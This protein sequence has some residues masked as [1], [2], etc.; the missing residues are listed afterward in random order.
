MSCLLQPETS[1]H[2]GSNTESV[3]APLSSAQPTALLHCIRLYKNKKNIVP[4]GQWRQKVK[5]STKTDPEVFFMQSVLKRQGLGVCTTQ[6]AD[7]ITWP[8][9]YP[10]SILGRAM[11]IIASNCYCLFGSLSKHHQ[12]LEPL[13]DRQILFTMGRKYNCCP[14]GKS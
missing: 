3:L 10:G 4:M 12:W 14:G 5:A 13:C 8:S 2:L 9:L 6:P 7:P 11:S 1:L